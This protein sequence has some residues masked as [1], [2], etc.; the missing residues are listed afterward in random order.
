MV[1]S[2]RSC[3]LSPHNL[4]QGLLRLILVLTMMAATTGAALFAQTRRD[5][6][7]HTKFMTAMEVTATRL[8][9]ALKEVGIREE[10]NPNRV[11]LYLASVGLRGDY[12]WCNVFQYWVWE[13]AAMKYGVK[14]PMVKSGLA[15]STFDKA[16]REGVETKYKASV[17]DL[18]IWKNVS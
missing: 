2:T 10:L 4:Y 3:N 13:Q 16:L 1:K 5:L 9:V 7:I 17:G 18:I 6:K 15:N 8:E 11:K 12:A 14:N